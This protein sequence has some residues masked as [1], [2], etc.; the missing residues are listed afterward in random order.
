MNH[1]YWQTS[2]NLLTMPQDKCHEMEE[3]KKR[4]LNAHQ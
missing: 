1:T 4:K 3:K 2:N